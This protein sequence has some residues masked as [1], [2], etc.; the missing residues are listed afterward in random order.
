MTN[1]EMLKIAMQQSAEDI[2]KYFTIRRG[3][4]QYKNFV[5]LKNRALQIGKCVVSYFG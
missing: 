3:K 5:I 1:Q 2:A 4:M